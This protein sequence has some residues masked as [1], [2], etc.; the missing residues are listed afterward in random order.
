MKNSLMM[1]LG[2]AAVWLAVPAPVLAQSG[3]PDLPNCQAW[4][5]YEGEETPTLRV[6]PEGS[7]SLFTAAQ[8]PDGTVV[9]GTV[10]LLLLDWLDVPIANYPHEDLWLESADGGLVPCPG[11]SVAD[12]DTDDTGLTWWVQPMRAGGYSQALTQVMVNG[13]NVWQEGLRL[14]F[15]SPDITGDGQVNLSDLGWFASDFFTQYHFRSDLFRDG[16]LNLSDLGAMVMG[17]Q[18]QCP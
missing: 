17:M 16:V 15:N 18:A 1:I 10:F 2:A 12:E 3:I 13:D 14:S 7:G 4:T 8:L 11:G 9:D 5:A 6:T